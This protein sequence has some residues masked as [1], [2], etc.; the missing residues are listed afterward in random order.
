MQISLTRQCFQYILANPPRPLT[1]ID[2]W[3]QIG[4]VYEQQQEY[5]AAKDAYDRVLQAN[6]NHA[7]VLQQLGGLYHRRRASF[8]DPDKSVAIL[9]KSLE[10][11]T[12]TPS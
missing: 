10:N 7:K 8:Y 9:T 12:S 1:E 11:G 3:F 2:I 6:P 5:D 4:H